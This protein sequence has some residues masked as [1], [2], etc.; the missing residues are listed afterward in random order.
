M[1]LCVVRETLLH[2]LTAVACR[3]CNV[4]YGNAMSKFLIR[5]YAIKSIYS[6]P[7]VKHGEENNYL[8]LWKCYKQW[9]HQYTE[10]NAKPKQSPRPLQLSDARAIY[11]RPMKRKSQKTERVVQVPFL[12]CSNALCS[13]NTNCNA[14]SREKTNVKMT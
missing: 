3:D 5:P 2:M 1:A 7:G 8:I 9:Y 11:F 12:H 14:E 10:R 6:E 13:E 4:C